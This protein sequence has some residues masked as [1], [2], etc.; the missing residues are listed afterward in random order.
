MRA[1]ASAFQI[2]L[3][4]DLPIFLLMTGL[5]ENIDA[6]QNEKNLTFLYRAPKIKLGPLNLGTIAD[7]YSQT[8]GLDRERTRKMAQL[9]RGYPFAF[10]VLGYYAWE[11]PENWEA[12]IR[13]FR[14]YLEEYAYE[15]IWSELSPTD[16]KVCA[17]IAGSPDGKTADVRE[18]LQFSTNQFN[19]YRMRLI[20]KG[21]VNG[22]E[23]GVV[24]FLLP[25]FELFVLDHT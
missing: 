6:L 22:E 16:K 24:R 8:L 10:Q 19:P 15:K 23:R 25:L 21:I 9:T 4:Q 3:R 1:F 12:V 20:R 7:N 11:E 5:Y 2:F 14:Q 13:D 17:A 18:T